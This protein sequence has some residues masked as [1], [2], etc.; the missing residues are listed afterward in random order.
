LDEDL[1]RALEEQFSIAYNHEGKS[2]VAKFYAEL[3]LEMDKQLD[4][5]MQQDA[6]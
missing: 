1:K 3:R 2:G 5:L 4:F 6:N